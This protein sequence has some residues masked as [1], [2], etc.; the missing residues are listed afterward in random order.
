MRIRICNCQPQTAQTAL[1]NAVVTS[2]AA[3]AA[4]L[5]KRFSEPELVSD[6][7]TLQHA[8]RAWRSEQEELNAVGSQPSRLT[9]LQPLQHLLGRIKPL[10]QP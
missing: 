1:A 5:H 3:H 9:T 4:A 7:S 10:R 8:L 2:S 6:N